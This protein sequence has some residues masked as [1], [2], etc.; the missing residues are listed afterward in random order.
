MHV[1]GQRVRTNLSVTVRRP[2]L[3]AHATHTQQ[4]G[5]VNVAPA[6]TREARA[7]SRGSVLGRRL[8][9]ARRSS[10]AH[11]Q[12]AVVGACTGGAGGRISGYSWYLSGR[13]AAGR[14]AHGR[15][16]ASRRPLGVEVVLVQLHV[17][18]AAVA[19]AT[20]QQCLRQ[21]QARLAEV[22]RNSRLWRHT[23]VA[24]AQSKYVS[25]TRVT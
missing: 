12:W 17:V 7:R 3:P 11:A 18:G 5:R 2:G 20:V 19:V 23:S 24:T 15:I 22:L 8:S 4:L 16:A 9:A 13:R 14:T 10:T 1:R 25:A 6:M 21:R